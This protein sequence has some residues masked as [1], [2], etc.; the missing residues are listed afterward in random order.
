MVLPQQRR[1]HLASKGSRINVKILTEELQAP[2]VKYTEFTMENIGDNGI[3]NN[4]A[5]NTWDAVFN[6]PEVMQWLV[7]QKRK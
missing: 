2:N 5:H 7:Q 3:V 1:Q 4:N 6:S